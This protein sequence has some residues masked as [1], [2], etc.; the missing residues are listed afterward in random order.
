MFVYE[1]RKIT[2]FVLW[3]VE[4]VFEMTSFVY[5]VRKM[6]IKSRDA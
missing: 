2:D 6:F 1:V 3:D 4:Y 5:D